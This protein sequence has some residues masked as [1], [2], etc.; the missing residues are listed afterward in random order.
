[1]KRLTRTE[2]TVGVLALVIALAGGSYMQSE[3]KA[4]TQSAGQRGFDGGPGR[5]RGPG[6]DGSRRGPGPLGDLMLRRLNLTATQ[7]D[8]VKQIVDAHKDAGK[9]LGE[10][11]RAA[12]EALQAAVTADELNEGAVR[13]AASDL[14]NVESDMAIERARVHQEV[15]QILTAEQKTTLKSLQADMK[16]RREAMEKRMD[17]RRNQ[18]Q[19]R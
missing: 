5:G 11:A 15:R 13:A 19:A 9:A 14:A 7:Q 4:Q 2:T 18:R 17:E 8:Q 10:R 16:A 3:L 1:M 12:Q 6:F